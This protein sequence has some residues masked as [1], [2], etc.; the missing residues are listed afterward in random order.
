MKQS[1]SFSL[2]RLCYLRKISRAERKELLRSCHTYNDYRNARMQ[3]T[4]RGWDIIKILSGAAI[5]FSLLCTCVVIASATTML[6]GISTVSFLFPIGM[7]GFYVSYPVLLF[8]AVTG[9]LLRQIDLR[10]Y[11]LHF[12]LLVLPLFLVIGWF[13]LILLM[14]LL[15]S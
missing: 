15:A 6:W 12:I 2:N 7:Y 8:I 11:L 13:M 3:I 14:A 4:A 1:Y 10:E 9:L 5:L